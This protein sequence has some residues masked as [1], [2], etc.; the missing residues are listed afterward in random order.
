MENKRPL[1]YTIKQLDKVWVKYLKKNSAELGISDTYR[2]I[3]MYL[4]SG[5]FHGIGEKTAS[6]IVKKLGKNAISLIK[7]DKNNLSGIRGL[8]KSKIDLSGFFSFKTF[9]KAFDIVVLPLPL[10]PV[11]A[12]FIVKT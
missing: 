4:S 8:S 9:K 7:E 1:M 3:I 10:F 11:I 12:I 5:L 6:N 2:Q